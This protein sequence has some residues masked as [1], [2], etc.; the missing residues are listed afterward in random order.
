M[1]DPN[2]KLAT[3]FSKILAIKEKF[4]TVLNSFEEYCG[5]NPLITKAEQAKILE[6]KEDLDA[7]ETRVLLVAGK[8][9]ITLGFEKENI[10]LKDKKEKVLNLLGGEEAIETIGDLYVTLVANFKVESLAIFS[11]KG[12]VVFREQ[13]I[14]TPSLIEIKQKFNNFTVE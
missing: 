5:Q 6:L 4:G 1:G 2:E 13:Q 10:D 11:S 3:Q 9:G 7:I 14:E 8:K 12:D